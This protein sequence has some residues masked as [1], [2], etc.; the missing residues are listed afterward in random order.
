MKLK[1][2]ACICLC[3]FLG[4]ETTTSSQKQIR[5][6][7]RH[8]RKGLL[9]MNFKNNTV[10]SRAEE[11][12]PWEYGLA[13]MLTTDIEMTGLFN[14][15]SKERLKDVV[16]QQEFQMTGMVDDRN[17]VEIG[18]LTAAQYILTGSFMEMRGNLRIESQVFSVEK[19]VQL[20]TACPKH[21]L[22][23][24]QWHFFR[25]TLSDGASSRASFRSIPILS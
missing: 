20:G 13:S 7:P 14:I 21:W 3:V 15:I 6:I 24:S 8:Q 17:M 16:G 9:V 2:L 1:I 12:E 18:R 22:T 25:D 4:C 23:S 19:G 11:F 10:K 5:K